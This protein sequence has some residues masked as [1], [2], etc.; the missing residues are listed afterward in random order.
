[1]GVRIITGV[2]GGRGQYA[3]NSFELANPKSIFFCLE[4][5]LAFGPVMPFDADEAD[6][7]LTWLNESEFRH[8]RIAG[9]VSGKSFQ[10][11]GAFGSA[12]PP[13]RTLDP[14]VLQDLMHEYIERQ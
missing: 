9:T 6:K 14:G 4:S 8:E 10:F 5:G 3:T 7:F 11:A 13:L 12:L 2:E 1:M